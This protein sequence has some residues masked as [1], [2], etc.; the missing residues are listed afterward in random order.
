MEMDEDKE[1]I[2]KEDGEET[3]K[4]KFPSSNK[5]QRNEKSFRNRF[6]SDFFFDHCFANVI[7]PPI[8]NKEYKI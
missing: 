3:P 7:F 8:E 5:T 4:A 6:F 1:I 2:Q